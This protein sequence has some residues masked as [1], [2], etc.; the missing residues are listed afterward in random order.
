MS[1]SERPN[2]PIPE[3][4]AID[5]TLYLD[6]HALADVS[7][8]LADYVTACR[9]SDIYEMHIV[10]GIRDAHGLRSIENVLMNIREVACFRSGNTDFEAHGETTVVL[11][12]PEE[13][14][15]A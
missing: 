8:V 10:H 3:A 15:P 4:P 11:L 9:D 14:P 12:R 2:R 7:R 6:A 1:V 5:G 13:L